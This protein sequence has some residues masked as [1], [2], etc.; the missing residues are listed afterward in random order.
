[1][2]KVIILL[3]SIMIVAGCATHKEIY[4]QETQDRLEIPP[5]PKWVYNTPEVKLHQYDLHREFWMP[6][7]KKLV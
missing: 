5:L 6:V 2:K 7:P 4:K 1:M 3:L